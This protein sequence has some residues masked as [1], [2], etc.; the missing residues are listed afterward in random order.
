MMVSERGKL[1][2]TPTG[3]IVLILVLV[4]DGLGATATVATGTRAAGDRK[5]VV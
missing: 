3:F 5:S 1:V 2:M 4:D